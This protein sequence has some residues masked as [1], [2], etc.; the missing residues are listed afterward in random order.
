MTC[1]EFVESYSEIHDGSAPQEVVRAAEEHLASCG[2]CRRYRHVL[3]RGAELL[4]A[5][6]APEVGQDFVPRLRR[7]LIQEDE[8]SFLRR[9]ANSGAT[10]LAVVGMAVLLTAVAWAPA[11]WRS[12]RVVE[13]PPIV[14][15]DP[16]ARMRPPV[17]FTA[18]APQLTATA[19]RADLWGDARTL[20]FQYS[21]LA[22][23]YGTPSPSGS[24]GASQGR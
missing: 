19:V 13:L 1:S 20:L 3:E 10:A 7:R 17:A 14:V 5:L 8:E 12:E 21:R 22:R 24:A 23:R 2:S 6:P 4:R 9:H 11:L 18:L 16:P 15:S